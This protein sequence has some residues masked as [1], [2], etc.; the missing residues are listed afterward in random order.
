M[1]QGTMLHGWKIGEPITK[2]WRGKYIHLYR[3]TKPC[4]QCGQEMVLD[5]TKKALAGTAKNSGF[6][7][8]RC[9]DCRATSRSQSGTSRPVVLNASQQP[10]APA[11]VTDNADFNENIELRAQLSEARRRIIKLEQQLNQLSVNKPGPW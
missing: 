8:T 5:V 7:L 9:P 11:S 2:W 3:I 10:V 1:L 4:A 6:Q